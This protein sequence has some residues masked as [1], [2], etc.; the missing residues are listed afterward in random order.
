V[1]ASTPAQLIEATK[2]EL[3][4]AAQAAV[5]DVAADTYN[6]AH[7]ASVVAAGRL[8]DA[9]ARLAAAQADDVQ[10]QGEVTSAQAALRVTALSA[11]VDLKPVVL[12][13]SPAGLDAVY[14]AGLAGAYGRSA[15]GTAT[16]RVRAFQAA[17]RRLRDVK[18]LV[19][20]VAKQAGND[21]G[22]AQGAERGAQGAAAAANAQQQK[23]MATLAKVQGSLIALVGAQRAAL[24]VQAYQNLSKPSSTSLDFQTPFPLP[25]QLPETQ[26]ALLLAL[27]QIGKP[28]VWGATGPSTFDCSGLMQWTWG[29][30]GV[31]MPRVAADQQAWA[32]PVPISQ[33]LPG[34]LVFFGSS[35]HHVGMYVGNGMMVNAPHTGAFVEVA[36]IW[37]SD[38][39][40]FGRVHR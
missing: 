33:L 35:A 23:L 4:I 1:I 19:S 40:G 10:A 15:A 11:Y 18:D 28:Y 7:A 38:L 6:K 14:R 32:V 22:A 5:L 39:A 31:H 27:A 21:A 29:Q 34:D 16:D 13:Q 30:L 36:P 12:T 26:A 17:E 25:S 3:Q 2:L 24:A 20:A 37:W 9:Q 8:A